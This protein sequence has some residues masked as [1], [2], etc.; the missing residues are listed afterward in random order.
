[1]E[2][3]IFKCEFCDRVFGTKNACNSHRGQCKQNINAKP[4]SEK[5]LEAMHK[6][7]DSGTNQYTKAKDLGLP[8]PVVSAETRRK[9][10]DAHRGDRNSSK[11][12]EVREKISASMKKAHA[13]GR[14]G[15][16]PS[17]KDNAMS[18]PEK[19]FVDIAE[20]EGIT[21]YVRELKF[22]RFFLDFAWPEKKFCIE[23]D[24]EQHERFQEQKERDIKKDILLKEEGWT[25]LRVSWS[26]VCKNAQRFIDAV[27]NNLNSLEDLEVNRLS[28]SYIGAKE[29]RELILQRKRDEAKVNGT[30]ASNGH[31]SG[32]KLSFE[33]W[34]RRKELIEKA[35][36]DLTKFGCV[37]ELVRKTCLTKRQVE[38]TLKYFSMRS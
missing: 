16:F 14:A 24:G 2:N 13:E 27:K 11:R 18:Y 7:R 5:W 38:K 36:V 34:D 35:N 22:H 29:E 12:A 21:G 32:N 17:R 37:A 10:G 4:K 1:M 3:M 28:L 20:R 19:W 9:I 30:L 31:L 25:E 23:I 6:R 15:S 26:W 33:E 8:P